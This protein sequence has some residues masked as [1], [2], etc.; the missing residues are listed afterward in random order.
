VRITPAKEF[1]KLNDAQVKQF[2]EKLTQLVQ[3]E[4]N[5]KVKAKP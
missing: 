5:Q 1:F 4:V 3:T 2:S